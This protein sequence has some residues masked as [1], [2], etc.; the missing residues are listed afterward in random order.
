MCFVLTHH[1]RETRHNTYGAVPLNE[2]PENNKVIEPHTGLPMNV[3]RY[4][5]G[6]GGTDAS[7]TVR[8]HHHVPGTDEN[9]RTGGSTTDWE[10]I[11]KADTP[12]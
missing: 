3:G 2:I 5:D 9:L 4:G 6:H 8:G 10:A 11:K 12:Y 7:P 1:V